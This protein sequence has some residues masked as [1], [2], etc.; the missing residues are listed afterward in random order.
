MNFTI[1]KHYVGYRY[2]QFRKILL[3]EIDERQAQKG[4]APFQTRDIN[5][6]GNMVR[7]YKEKNIVEKT[8]H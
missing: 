8:D 5:E 1:N 4:F 6:N 7:Y 3:I 2:S